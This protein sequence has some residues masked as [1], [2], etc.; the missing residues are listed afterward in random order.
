M[1]P[2]AGIPRSQGVVALLLAVAV[3]LALRFQA[4]AAQL[5]ED[6][7]DGACPKVHRTVRRVLKRAH[8]D[9]V[10]IYASLTRLHFHDCFVQGCD[11]SILL[12]NSSSIVS[13][14]FA[15]PNNNSARGFEVVDAVKA[16]LEEACPGV[17]SC[18]D[19]LAIAA[20]ISVELV[21]P[22]YLYL[23]P[24][25]SWII[26]TYVA[27]HLTRPDVDD[28]TR[29]K[30]FTSSFPCRS[31]IRHGHMH[32]AW[33]PYTYAVRRPPVARSPR[34][35]RRHHRQHHRREQPPEPLRQPHQAPAEVRR[36]WP[37]R[38][39]PRRTLRYRTVP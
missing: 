34:P 35:A 2:R 39:R 20:K 7:Y 33:S 31:L 32:D 37:R 38:H 10:R 12:D 5:S 21:R 24:K 16:A 27:S 13:E 29:T 25:T 18:A 15:T 26:R 30:P 11:A 36:R 6:Y 4:G 19:V 3:V 1:A 9:D 22:P 28:V 17:V 14:K 23:L 8:A